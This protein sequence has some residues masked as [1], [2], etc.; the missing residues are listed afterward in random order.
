MKRV[1]AAVDA[2]DDVFAGPLPALSADMRDVLVWT[3]AIRL[4]DACDACVRQKSSSGLE[5]NR[6][7]TGRRRATRSAG[8]IRRAEAREAVL[9]EGEPGFLNAQVVAPRLYDE[10]AK[11]RLTIAVAAGPSICGENREIDPLVLQMSRLDARNV[12]PHLTSGRRSFIPL[13]MDF[14]T[15]KIYSESWIWAKLLGPMA[16]RQSNV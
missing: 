16:V 2:R 6:V 14:L 15:K 13:S 11:Q 7:S 10:P 12:L 8:K 5:V 4:G 3:E 9:L 1:R